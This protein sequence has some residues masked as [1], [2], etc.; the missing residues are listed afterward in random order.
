VTYDY[1]CD[2]CGKKF[3]ALNMVNNR[4]YAT[5]PK[6]GGR[7]DMKFSVNGLTKS[8]QIFKP[9]LDYN[10]DSNPIFI[11]TRQQKRDLLKKNNLEQM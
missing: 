6:C 4:H 2:E 11:E 7:A 5:C 8:I 9:Y 3:E 1:K 10:I